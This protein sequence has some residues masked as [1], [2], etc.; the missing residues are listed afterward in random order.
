MWK[1][2]RGGGVVNPQNMQILT[3]TYQKKV[4]WKSTSK[5]K[6]KHAHA[7]IWFGAHWIP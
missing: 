6:N 5:R 2:G 4:L 1:R 3:Q 7:Y